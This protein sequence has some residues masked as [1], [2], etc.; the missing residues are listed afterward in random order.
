MPV[1]LFLTKLPMWVKVGAGM[2]LL[3]ALMQ[4]VNWWNT[5]DLKR[6]LATAKQELKTTQEEAAAASAQRALDA[7]QEEQNRKDQQ[8]AINKTNARLSTIA[9]Q[10][11]E[12]EALAALAANRALKESEDAADALV[13]PSSTIPTDPAS[14]NRRLRERFGIIP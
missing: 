2:G 4:V 8:A 9:A 11:R 3:L 14:L 7:K 6:D 5:R 13:D 10:T 1:W 12:A